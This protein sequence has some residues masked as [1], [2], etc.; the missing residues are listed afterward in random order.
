MKT[1]WLTKI[2]YLPTYCQGFTVE[3]HQFP[4]QGIWHQL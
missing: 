4:L 2:C 3:S 1:A